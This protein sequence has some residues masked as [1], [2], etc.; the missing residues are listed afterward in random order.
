MGF[1]RYLVL[2]ASLANKN[3]WFWG[4]FFSLFWIIL[5]AYI[6]TRGG[7]IIQYGVTD[8]ARQYMAD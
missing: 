7:N 2:R 3:V 4:V 8:A 1:I 6:F 5:A